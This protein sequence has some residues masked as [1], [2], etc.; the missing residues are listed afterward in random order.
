MNATTVVDTPVLDATTT[1]A[2]LAF[3]QRLVPPPGR[4][5]ERLVGSTIV[6][7]S[8][9][10]VARYLYVVAHRDTARRRNRGLSRC[11]RVINMWYCDLAR[12][13][14]G[15]DAMGACNGASAQFER[16]PGGFPGWG[17]LRGI[18]V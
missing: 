13:S 10:P 7:L 16:I 9:V 14:V 11:P 6:A 18:P 1:P 15:T 2:P 4:M 5:A 12:P 17:E 8:I 3:R